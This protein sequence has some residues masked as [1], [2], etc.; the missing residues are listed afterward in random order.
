[1]GLT[2]L[3]NISTDVAMAGKKV[4]ARKRKA[5]P[6]RSKLPE[7][8]GRSH[9]VQVR[10]KPIDRERLTQLRG[11][12]SESTWCYQAVLERIERELAKK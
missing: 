12:V 8:E 1:M 10:L 2:G 3:K 9:K 5:G 4:S 11:P 6:G 7:G